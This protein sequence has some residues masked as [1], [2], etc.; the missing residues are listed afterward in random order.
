MDEGVTSFKMFMAYP[1]VFLVDDATIFRA[2]SAAGS[3]GGS[4]YAR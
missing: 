3:R 1:G 4:L 2:M